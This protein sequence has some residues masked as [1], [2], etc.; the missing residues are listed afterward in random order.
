[1]LDYL[2]EFT[3]AVEVLLPVRRPGES[4]PVEI[5]EY[6]DR[7]NAQKVSFVGYTTEN[8][9]ALFFKI[10]NEED[11]TAL[12]GANSCQWKFIMVNDNCHDRSNIHSS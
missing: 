8:G 10:A 9:S 12:N 11:K 6:Y 5:T 1:M 7:M 3:E 2:P 4:L